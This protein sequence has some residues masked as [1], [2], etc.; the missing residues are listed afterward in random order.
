MSP[1]RSAVLFDIDGTLVDTNYFHTL[2][3]WRAL[4]DAGENVPM[5]KVHPLIGMGSDKLVTS[6]LGEERSGMSDAHSEQFVPFKSEIVAFAKAGELL[7]EVARRGPQVVLATSS[8]ESDLKEMLEAIGADEHITELVHGDQV[9]ASKPAPDIFATAL[10]LLQLDGTQTIVVGDTR[11]DVEAA[12]AAGV[13]AVAVLTGGTTRDDLEAAGAIAVYADVAELLAEL[14]ESPLARLFGEGGHG[15]QPGPSSVL[16]EDLP[17][18]LRSR[19]EAATA[20]SQRRLL[21]R[22]PSQQAPEEE[23]RVYALTSDRVVHMVLSLRPDGSVDE[24]TETFLRGQI[25]RVEIQGDEAS[26]EVMTPDGRRSIA[27]PAMV[28]TDLQANT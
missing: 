7:A 26:L 28:A 22:R 27:V 6:L 25:T 23:Y 17:H 14:D 1:L 18:E 9:A 2:A 24:A 12:R 3:W 20:H 19:I 11:W 21:E 5:A 8:K 13:D 4:R 15:E 10:E 16:L